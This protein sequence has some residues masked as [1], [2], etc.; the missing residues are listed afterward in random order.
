LRILSIYNDI[1]CYLLDV[2]CTLPD[3]ISLLKYT[4]FKEE[5]FSIL[6]FVCILVFKVSLSEY[7]LYSSWF[8]NPFCQSLPFNWTV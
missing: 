7:S 5:V 3:N 6:Q 8:L 2:K 1:S 4:V